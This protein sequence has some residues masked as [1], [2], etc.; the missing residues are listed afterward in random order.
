MKTIIAIGHK[1]PDTDSIVASLIFADFLKKVRKPILGFLNFKIKPARAGSLNKETKFVF[2][3]F[4]QTPPPL[5][6]NLRNE[7]VVLV[8]HGSYEEAAD[9]VE[10]AR[11]VGVLDHHKLGGLRTVTPIFYRAEPIGSTSTILAKMF[12]ENKLSFDK[13]TEGFLLA[14]ILSDTLK[15]TS[16]TTTSEDRRIVKILAKISKEN[17]NKL[18]QKMFEAKSDIKGISFNELVSKDYKEYKDGGINFG[19]GVWETV[20]PQ[21]IKV[22]EKEILSAL[23]KLKK[24]RKM[25]L[26]FF[27]LVDILKKNSEVFLLGEKEK[28]IAEKVFKKRAKGSLL[29]LSGVVSR[30]KQIT[31]FLINFLE[32]NEPSQP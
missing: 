10:K 4:K 8:D 15:L 29:F 16:P 24:K 3:Y 6:K 25:K 1:N 21:K 2:N 32:K 18:A 20:C 11:I 30:K 12:L 31:P 17:I 9:G 7:N 26:M 23:E 19:V 14:A 13:K 28:S 27:A 22:K 5:V